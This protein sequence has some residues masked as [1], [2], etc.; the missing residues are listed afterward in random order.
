MFNRLFSSP[1][2]EKQI[3]RE[4]MLAARRNI[5]ATRLDAPQHAARQFLDHID[6]P[7]SAVLALYRPIRSEL[8]TRP[9]ADELSHRGITLCLPVIIKKKSPLIFREWSP[10]NPLIEGHYKVP[11]PEPTCEQL[12]PNF[13]LVPLLAFDGNGR[14]LGYGGGYYDR[15]L[16]AL[17]QE[18][19]VSAIGYGF[20]DQRVDQCPNDPLDERINWIVTEREASRFL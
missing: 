15:T 1:Y 16:A 17:R 12:R 19:N 13:I 11:E 3:L 9:L 20:A 5:A 6:L 2:S 7:E 4:K 10:G 18:G 8:D 14:R